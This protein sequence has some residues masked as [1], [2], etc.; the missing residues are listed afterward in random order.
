MKKYFTLEVKIALTAIVA[1]VILFY[2]INFLKGINLFKHSNSYQVEFADINGLN[3][4]SP[5]YANGYSVGQ[6]RSINYN[7]T[8]PGHV[9]VQIDLDKSMRIPEGSRAELVSSLMGGVTMNLI[10][11]KNPIAHLA[12]GDTLSGEIYN[13]AVERV[14]EMMPQIEKLIPKLDSILTS[15]N[16][17]LAD[18]ALQRSLHHVEGL[19]ANLEQGTAQLNTLLS[20][21]VPTLT[22]HLDQVSRHADELVQKY[23]AIDVEGT[24]RGVNTTLAGVDTTIATLNHSLSSKDNSL[25]LLLNDRRVYDNLSATTENANALLL[26]LRQ[27][28]KR[29]V[30]FSVFGKKDK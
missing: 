12:P 25:G 23:A 24:L 2:G 6:V 13:G 26:D 1:I 11:G 29:Y 21:D 27:H 22:R 18:P 10:L 4:S 7:Y 15:I 19:T 9:V 17:L 30:H 14:T 16:L 28:P 3:I 8:N 20:K 5:V